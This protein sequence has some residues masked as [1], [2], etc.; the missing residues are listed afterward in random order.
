MNP[1]DIFYGLYFQNSWFG[2]LFK[3]YLSLRQHF[4]IMKWF[5]ISKMR[6]EKSLRSKPWRFQN[7]LSHPSRTN[8]NNTFFK[9]E[10]SEVGGFQLDTYCLFYPKLITYRKWINQVRGLRFFVADN[11]QSVVLL[12]TSVVVTT[13]VLCDNHMSYSCV[14]ENYE[15]VTVYIVMKH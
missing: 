1:K 12:S 2:L 14:G 6:L 7:T 9:L 10:V 4:E 8:S 5:G 3:D 15:N 11:K 13:P